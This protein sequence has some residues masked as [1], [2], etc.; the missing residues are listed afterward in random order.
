[1]ITYCRGNILLSDSQAIVIPV[2]L[3][4]VAGAGLAKQWAKADPDAAH[5]YKKLCKSNL[6]GMGQVSLLSRWILF[7]T[8]DDWRN[9]SQID[10]ILAGLIDLR[11]RN[12]TWRLTS[13]AIPALGCG[14][15]SL[16]WTQVRTLMETVLSPLTDT[17]I[18][19]Y[20]PQPY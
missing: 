15:G 11:L 6:V 14:L 18:N 3:L 16:E 12:Y 1:M 7:P 19:I 20:P 9:P 10:H 2:N 17:Q 13:I 4:G 5:A 8:K